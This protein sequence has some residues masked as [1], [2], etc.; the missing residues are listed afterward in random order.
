MGG[1]LMSDIRNEHLEKIIN[2]IFSKKSTA[3]NEGKKQVVIGG[4][5]YAK[6]CSFLETDKE[7]I[8]IFLNTHS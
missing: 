6:K 5:R 4:G 7:Y 1:K 2:M 8:L 3:I